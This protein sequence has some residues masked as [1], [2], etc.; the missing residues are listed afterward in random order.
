VAVGLFG[1]R[2]SVT[3]VGGPVTWSVS[4]TGA[5]GNSVLV[6]GPSSGT[7]AAGASASLLIVASRQVTGAALTVSPGGA[8]YP[9]VISLRL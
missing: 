4:V 2:I 3:A 8:T 7:L 9:L 1:T 6:L 5:T